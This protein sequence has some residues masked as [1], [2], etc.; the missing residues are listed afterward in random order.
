M[1]SG[2]AA[3]VWENILNSRQIYPVDQTPFH[4][5]L[6]TEDSAGLGARI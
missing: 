3:A 1:F 4:A 2:N 6:F 5:G